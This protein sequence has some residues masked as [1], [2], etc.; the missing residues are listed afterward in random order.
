LKRSGVIVGREDVVLNG[1]SFRGLNAC[2]LLGLAG[3]LAGTPV[4][5]IAQDRSPGIT[6]P[7]VFPPFDP[8]AARCAA[9]KGL[10][11]ALGFVQDN[12][13]AFIEGV[14]FGL[15]QAASDR[16]LKYTDIVA[17]NDPALEA[18]D[19]QHLIDANYGAIVTAPVDPQALAPTLQKQIWA[20]G[21]VG[22]V[23]PP[24]AITVLNAP[25]YLTGKTLG[26]AAAGYIRDHLGGKA[27]VVLLT[28]DSLQFLAPRFTAI[29]DTLK[30]IPGVN[31]IA[32]LSPSP[33]NGEG[34]YAAMKLVLEANPNVDV[35]LGADTVVLGALKALREAGKDR[36]D[37]Y[38]GGIDGEP[39]A[40]AELQK[41]NSP[42]KASIAL[43]SP[44]FGYA[45]GANA[46]D[47]LEGKSVPQAMDALP[48]ALTKDILSQYEID[49]ANPA[50]VY[51]DPARLAKYLKRYGNI[52]F[53]SRAQYVNFPWSS[54][55]N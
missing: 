40:I 49:Q 22:T 8:S 27:D 25:Q 53:D 54:E 6:A 30:S 42:Y 11:K 15:K 26:D 24:P 39:E 43:S 21:Y 32:D 33:V 37:Q 3:V 16:G 2:A 52:C 48:I 46:A 51:T 17:D 44:V 18:S 38:L 10:I 9:P 7:V 23:V 5:A 29:R 12:R 28:Q 1:R 35:V 55:G 4:L 14:G 45:L 36:P 50:A 20:G 13:R 31:V 19:I 34:G 41:G 47:W